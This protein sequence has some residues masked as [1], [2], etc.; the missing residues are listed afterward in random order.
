QRCKLTFSNLILNHSEFLNENLFSKRR[1]SCFLRDDNSNEASSQR[2][3]NSEMKGTRSNDYNMHAVIDKTIFTLS[4][5]LNN[6]LSGKE[7]KNKN[8]KHDIKS[9]QP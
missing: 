2:A 7:T 3:Q 4:E 6:C 5:E 8:E 9:D 1:A